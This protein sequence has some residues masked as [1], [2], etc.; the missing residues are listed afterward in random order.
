[1]LETLRRQVHFVKQ[2]QG[3][4]TEGVEPLVC[5]RDETAEYAETNTLGLAQLKPWLD[6]EAVD[7]NGTV[8]S[9]KP[10]RTWWRTWDVFKLGIDCGSGYPRTQGRYFVLKRKGNRTE[11]AVMKQGV[12]RQKAMD[13]NRAINGELMETRPLAFRKQF[14]HKIKIKRAAPVNIRRTGTVKAQRI[15]TVRFRKQASR[16]RGL[17]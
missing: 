11:Q 17:D 10:T 14:Y 3:V 2:V 5:I 13:R 16:I 12:D 9:R 4:D 15:V 1:M 7:R 8:R 6:Q